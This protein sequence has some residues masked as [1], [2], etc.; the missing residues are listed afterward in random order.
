MTIDQ[1]KLAAIQIGDLLSYYHPETGIE[2]TGICAGWS[3]VVRRPGGGVLATEKHVL[4]HEKM[5]V[6][7]NKVFS[8]E[9]QTGTDRGEITWR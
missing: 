1:E 2:E 3:D 4:V 9:R 8:R 5:R 7:L 6:P